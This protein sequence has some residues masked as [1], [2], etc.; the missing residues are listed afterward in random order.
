[1]KRVLI[2]GT[3]AVLAIVFAC[4]AIWAQAVS[5]AQIVGTVKDQTGAVLPGAEVAATQ[6]DTGAK[7][8][9][10][11]DEAGYYSLPNLPVGPYRVEVTLP[12]FRAYVQTGIILQV[13]SNPVI[14]AILAVGQVSEQIE[15]QADA[16]LV[17]TRSTG[18]GQVM[19]NQRVLELPLNGRQAT[20]LI[21]L[22]GMA[23]PTTAPGLNPGSGITRRS[24]FLLPVECREA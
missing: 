4:A 12:G 5:T 21:F 16:A 14:N 22:A 15:V 10:L 11:T 8:T 3:T 2:I 9:A 7:R 1:M 13:N 6:T 24:R 18:V 23:A 20:E 17:E 19:D